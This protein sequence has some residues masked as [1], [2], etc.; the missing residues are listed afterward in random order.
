M[1]EAKTL[2]LVRHA[3]ASGTAANQ[4]DFDRPLNACGRRD[5]PEMGKRLE[6]RGV[7]PDVLISSPANRA[8]Q[9][10]EL[11]ATELGIAPDAIVFKSAIYEA[12]VA[13]LVELIESIDPQF[14]SAMLVG[15]NPAL[16]WLINQLTGSHIQ[17]V[18][19]SG[20]ATL[21]FP[22][23]EWQTIAGCTANLLN[24]D[25]PENIAP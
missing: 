4:T 16:T 19:P 15:H 6:E 23:T 17:N 2:Y 21:E 13:T 10:A 11:I 9:T 22:P 25:I 8:T 12:S 5:A 24:F 3:H 1:P 18:P 14:S 7:L 20:I